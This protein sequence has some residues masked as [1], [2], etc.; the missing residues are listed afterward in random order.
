MGKDGPTLPKVGQKVLTAPT[1]ASEFGSLKN[2]IHDLVEANLPLPSD[3]QIY[4]A[5]EK[6]KDKFVLMVA[7]KSDRTADT[8][9][10]KLSLLN[11]SLYVPVFKCFR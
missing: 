4:F 9:Q 7:P 8:E 5:F 10:Y 2:D 1:S 3:T 6:A 11:V